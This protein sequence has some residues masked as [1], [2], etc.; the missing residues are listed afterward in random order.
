M[1]LSKVEKTEPIKFSFSVLLDPDPCYGCY[2]EPTCTLTYLIW[3]LDIPAMK[4]KQD[5]KIVNCSLF[6]LIHHTA[7]SIFRFN[8]RLSN[9]YA[10]ILP[11]LEVLNFNRHSCAPKVCSMPDINIKLTVNERKNLTSSSLKCTI[12]KKLI[13]WNL[14]H[15]VRCFVVIK[16][17][18]TLRHQSIEQ[19]SINRRLNGL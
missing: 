11:K 10:C 4:K 2:G 7:H 12:T 18:K 15:I 17:E 14:L 16:S 13:V 6:I 5:S 8:Y 19:N 9:G 1:C 3:E